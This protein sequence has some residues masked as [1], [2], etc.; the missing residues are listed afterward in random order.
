[1]KLKTRVFEICKEKGIEPDSLANTMHISEEYI[2]KVE[3][4]ETDINR[5]FIVESFKAFPDC[6]TG[7]LFFLTY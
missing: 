1:M 5:K 3:K 7:E 2:K 4:G 6:N